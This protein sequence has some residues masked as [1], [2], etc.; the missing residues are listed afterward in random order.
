MIEY[1]YDVNSQTFQDLVIQ[2]SYEKPVAVDFWAPWCAPCRTLKPILEKLTES[3]GGEVILAKLNTEEEPELATDYGIRGIPNVKIFKDG[4]V[5]DEF[6][7]VL[8]E[9][10]IKVLFQKYIQTELDFFFNDIQGK[11]LELKKAA[12]EKEFEKYKT[13]LKYL[14]EYGKTLFLTANYEKALE[15]FSLMPKLNE[16]EDEIIDMK[17][18]IELLHWSTK[19]PKDKYEVFLVQAAKAYS[20]NRMDDTLNFLTDLLF[21][22][23]EYLEGS[24]KKMAIAL[25]HLCKDEEKKASFFRKIS[26]AINA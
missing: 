6:T 18:I 19:D 5:V 20:E 16:F 1:I 25:V 7:G 23:K 9:G 24:V 14:F 11:D 17:I 26:M 4:Q 21:R 13:N 10:D 22:K 8:P 2:K 3:L 12:L 15:I